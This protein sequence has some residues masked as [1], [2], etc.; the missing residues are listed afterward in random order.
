MSYNNIIQ[1]LRLDDS[2]HYCR[3]LRMNTDTFEELL[4]LVAQILTKKSTR[5]INPVEEKLAC[6]LRFVTL[7][8]IPS[9]SHKRIKSALSS[10]VKKTHNFLGSHL[11]NNN[12]RLNR[13][14]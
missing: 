10:S 12:K 13:S 1:E 7:Y 4:T 2:E 6:T 8:N 5:L 11:D 3:Y 14:S 9:P